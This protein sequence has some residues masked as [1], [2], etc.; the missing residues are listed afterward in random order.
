[1]KT[2]NFLPYLEA[3]K[4][5]NFG[6]VVFWPFWQ[7]KSRR[8]QDKNILKYLEWYFKKWKE[9]IF[10]KRLN[11][12]IASL[13]G[14]LLGPFSKEEHERM[15]AACNILFHLS[16]PKNN[17]FCAL[18]SDNFTLY[19]QNFRGGELRLAL[20]TGS[21][22]RNESMLASEVSKKIKF[23]K[24]DYIPNHGAE[25]QL[26]LSDKKYYGAI[27][28]AFMQEYDS[29][30]FIR[31]TRSLTSF[32]SS[33]S[34]VY[35]IGYFDRILA[36]VTAIEILLDIDTS[37]SSRFIQAVEN[38]MGFSNRATRRSRRLADI[39]RDIRRFSGALYNKRS[40]YVHGGVVTEND[41]NH[42]RYGEY[43][44]T[45][46]IFYYELVKSLLE[47]ISYFSKRRI[48]HKALD[49]NFG[50]FPYANEEQD[51]D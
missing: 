32:V 6:D 49:Y 45:G 30:W 26:W 51:E 9:N 40:T 31:F 2:I 47:K 34:N 7:L 37:S 12:T 10:N 4:E 41:V 5:F 17:L 33:Y 20:A 22:I 43:Y 16:A 25:H 23:I 8:I 19:S 14:K 48:A 42:P 36:L 44:K 13:E 27:R 1:M 35:S 21:Y 46:V 24:P 28:K 15:R 38:T 39:N 50:L 3:K 18:S 29:D 11:I